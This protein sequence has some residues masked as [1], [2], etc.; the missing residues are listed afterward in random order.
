[1]DYCNDE[2]FSPLQKFSKPSIP[3][4]VGPT[5]PTGPPGPPSP[6]GTFLTQEAFVNNFS[7]TSISSTTPFN[8]EPGTSQIIDF[9]TVG[10]TFQATATDT[11]LSSTISGDYE[12]TVFVDSE[13]TT[14]N[15]TLVVLNNGAVVPSSQLII[16]TGRSTIGTTTIRVNGQPNIQLQNQTSGNLQLT[17]RELTL[18]RLGPPII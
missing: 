7:Y 17:R 16:G 2:C 14:A 11:S 13:P 10:P 9:D 12:V 6:T 15:A 5:G 4:V 1:M 3:S 18:K 8:L